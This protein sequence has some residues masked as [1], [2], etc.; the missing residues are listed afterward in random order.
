MKNLNSKT[1]DTTELYPMDELVPVMYLGTPIKMVVIGHTDT[2]V[3]LAY[4]KG[5]L[6]SCFY[7][8]K[9]LEWQKEL[10]DTFNLK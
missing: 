8:P 3:Q 1:I 7:T 10:C 5:S 9:E 4:I 2:H 6:D